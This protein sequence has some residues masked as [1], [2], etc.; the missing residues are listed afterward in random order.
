MAAERNQMRG[1]RCLGALEKYEE[2]L[3]SRMHGLA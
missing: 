1:V 3:G 2:E